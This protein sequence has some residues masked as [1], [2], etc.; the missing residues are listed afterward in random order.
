MKQFIEIVILWGFIFFLAHLIYSAPSIMVNF[1]QTWRYE[2][3]LAKAKIPSGPLL[4]F[5]II[6]LNVRLNTIY[7][8]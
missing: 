7:T 6:K 1:E 3:E 4:K 5:F 8:S 2:T